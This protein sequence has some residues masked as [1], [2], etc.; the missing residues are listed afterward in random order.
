MNVPF[1]LLCWFNVVF[2]LVLTHI[3]T[4]D[5]PPKRRVWLRGITWVCF[6]SLALVTFAAAVLP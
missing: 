2:S 1:M 5:A 3:L 6:V 4:D